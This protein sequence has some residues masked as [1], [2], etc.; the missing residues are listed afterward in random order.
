MIALI[1]LFIW[2]YLIIKKMPNQ[3]ASHIIPEPIKNTSFNIII[4]LCRFLYMVI[5]VLIRIWKGPG[6]GG[7]R[8][9]D[10][11]GLGGTGPGPGPNDPD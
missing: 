9:P 6:P 2:T 7:G 11:G 1:L 8:G 4:G 3:H 5:C 10:E